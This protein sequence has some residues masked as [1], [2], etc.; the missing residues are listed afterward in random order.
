MAPRGA[1]F[2]VDPQGSLG[3]VLET[4][5][6]RRRGPILGSSCGSLR[7]NSWS[8]EG[9][10]S[11]GRVR[12]GGRDQSWGPSASDSDWDGD[13]R[14]GCECGFAASTLTYPED[15]LPPS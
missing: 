14:R 9:Q 4:Q 7:A 11:E 13:G 3:H 12:A 1:A 5:R 10:G 2:S 15:A 6:E 8:V